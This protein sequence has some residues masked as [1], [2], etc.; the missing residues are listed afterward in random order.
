[1]VID[2]GNKIWVLTD[3]GFEGSQ[4]GYEKPGLLKID[5]ET[6]EIERTFRFELGEHP[7]SLS[8]NSTKDTLYYIN[9]HVWKMAISEKHLPESPFIQSE[10]TDSYGGFFSLGIDS[11]SSEIYVGDAIDHRQNGIVYRYSLSG[12]LIDQFKTGIS[13]GSFA[14]KKE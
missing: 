14:F 8:I 5:A 1:M 10:Y 3:G 6:H 13:P 12:K 11:V 2:R 9:G 7:L 4:F